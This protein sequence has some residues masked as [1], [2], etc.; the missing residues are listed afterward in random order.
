MRY[1]LTA[2]LSAA[3]ALWLSGCVP[4]PPAKPSAEVT[5]GQVAEADVDPHAG[6]DHAPGEGHGPEVP[7]VELADDIPAPASDVLP[8][9]VKAL[10]EQLADATDDAELTAQVVQANF[11]LGHAFMTDEAL[12][13]RIKYRTALKYLRRSLAL[14]PT[15]AEALADKGLIERIYRDVLHRPV[16][17]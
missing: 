13:P 7:P 14:D 5:G 2:I 6:H 10:E 3:V 9:D 15:H 8:A 17:E 4:P 11:E 1:L 16:P 12:P